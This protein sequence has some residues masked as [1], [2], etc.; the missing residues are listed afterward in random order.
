MNGETGTFTGIFIV[1]N[2][3]FRTTST[4][5]MN[6]HSQIYWCNT[7]IDILYTANFADKKIDIA[8]NFAMNFMRFEVYRR[9]GSS[10]GSSM[11]LLLTN[12]IDLDSSN[13]LCGICELPAASHSS[14]P[15]K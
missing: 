1:I 8:P 9:I 10:I 4:F 6:I 2:R 5:S 13:S 12:V 11:I 3:V 14:Q 15:K 7:F